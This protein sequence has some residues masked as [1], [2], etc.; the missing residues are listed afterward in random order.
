MRFDSTLGALAIAS[1]MLGASFGCGG[2]EVL[3]VGGPNGG[4]L[5][6]AAVGEG[7]IVGD[8]DGV[9]PVTYGSSAALGGA[10][11]WTQLYMAYFAP[12]TIGDCTNSGSCHTG[13]MDSPAHAFAYMKTQAQVGAP[14][15][16]LVDPQYSCLTWISADGDM[17]PAGPTMD[18]NSL[19]A[20][21]NWAKAGAQNN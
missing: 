17:P 5:N 8:G 4:T 7:G 13:E 18:Q 14:M 11:T 2:A 12:G 20:F 19:Q 1:A 16:D 9:Q 3:P 10:P 6:A 21:S 15:P